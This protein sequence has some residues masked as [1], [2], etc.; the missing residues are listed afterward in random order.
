M[1]TDKA[2]DAKRYPLVHSYFHPLLLQQLPPERFATT[3]NKILSGKLKLLIGRLHQK[4][5]A[6]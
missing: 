2:H 3:V 4:Q 5:E 6:D 1:R